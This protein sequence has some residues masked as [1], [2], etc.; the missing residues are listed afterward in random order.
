[1]KSEYTLGIQV[2]C[3][4]EMLRP[5]NKKYENWAGETSDCSSASSIEHSGDDLYLETL[6]IKNN[7]FIL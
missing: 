2:E 7:H 6:A 3:T 5:I 1:M 4:F